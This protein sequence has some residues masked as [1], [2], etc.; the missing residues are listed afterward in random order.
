[1]KTS[2]IYNCRGFSTIYVVGTSFEIYS[3]FAFIRW[4]STTTKFLVDSESRQWSSEPLVMSLCCRLSFPRMP[5]LAWR[6]FGISIYT[7]LLPNFYGGKFVMGIKYYQCEWQHFP[8]FRDEVFLYKIVVSSLHS[9]RLQC[10]LK[11]WKHSVFCEVGL[12]YSA[13]DYSHTFNASEIRS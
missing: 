5:Q 8:S 11:E 3:F 10:R 7:Y 12:D 6:C 13:R 1:M 9:N 4:C 2:L